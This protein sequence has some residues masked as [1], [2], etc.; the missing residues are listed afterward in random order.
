MSDVKFLPDREAIT[1][2]IVR[3]ID[4]QPED[5]PILMIV[6]YWGQGAEDILQIGKSFK[7][8]CNLADGG[9]NPRAVESILRRNDIKAEIHSMANLHAK[10][11]IGSSG[12][13][14]SS[15]NMSDNGLQILSSNGNLEAGIYVGRNESEYD[16]IRS[17]GWQCW[18]NSQEVTQAVLDQ[19][20]ASYQPRANVSGAE[21]STEGDIAAP[22]ITNLQ[23]YGF[24]ESTLFLPER[25]SNQSNMVRTAS[26]R[27]KRSHSAMLNRDIS[28]T[29]ARVTA[30]VANLLWTHAGHSIDWKKGTFRYPIDVVARWRDL[31]VADDDVYELLKWVSQ[32]KDLGVSINGC[33][34]EIIMGS[35][36]QY[37]VTES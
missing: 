8:V 27:L 19:A 24:T 26:K 9:T 30:Y 20:L 31:K 32:D 2:T 10:V 12:A 22:D 6:A 5:E 3:L 7:I 13:V 29:D 21:N 17:W 35:W 23:D 14:V 18:M 25:E 1:N 36:D 15:S 28:K 16:G 11:V 4:E 37:V 34:K 33:A